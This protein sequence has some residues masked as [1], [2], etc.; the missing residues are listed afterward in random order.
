MQQPALEKV[1]HGQRHLLDPR[2]DAVS[3]LMTGATG[4]GD[5][6]AVVRDQAAILDGAAPQIAGQIRHHPGPVGIAFPDVDI[7]ACL[8]RMAETVEEMNIAGTVRMM[9]R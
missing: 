4:E 1:R 7:P 8:R 9:W 3:L 2:T 5:A 6:G